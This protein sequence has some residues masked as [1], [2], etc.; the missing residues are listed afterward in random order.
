MQEGFQRQ[1][2]DQQISMQRM[3]YMMDQLM[4]KLNNS[5][6]KQSSMPQHSYYPHPTTAR[7][8]DES[9]CPEQCDGSQLSCTESAN[10]SVAPTVRSKATKKGGSKVNTAV[11]PTS[12]TDPAVLAILSAQLEITQELLANR[13]SSPTTTPEGS[14]PPVQKVLQCDRTSKGQLWPCAACP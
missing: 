7:S 12:A 5:G 14:A 10:Q 11:P 8:D 6:P 9:E 4:S 1:L 13:K 3:E 2:A